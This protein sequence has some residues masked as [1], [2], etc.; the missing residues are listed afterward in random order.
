MQRTSGGDRRVDRIAGRRHERELRH[1][2]ELAPV[3]VPVGSLA[4]KQRLVLPTLEREH[5]SREVRERMQVA[6]RLDLLARQ[7]RR[8]PHRLRRLRLRRRRD[9][10]IDAVA[11][12]LERGAP[13]LEPGDTAGDEQP[14]LDQLVAEGRLIR[15]GLTNLAH[16]GSFAINSN[17]ASVA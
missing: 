4:L 9:P 2:L 13:A 3:L 10:G 16:Q 5:R 15:G 1:P 12:V 17:A 11:D 8:E 14:V 7:Q 6:D